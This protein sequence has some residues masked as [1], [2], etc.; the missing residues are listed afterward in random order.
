MARGDRYHVYQIF[1][2]D[3][4]TGLGPAI[5]EDLFLTALP[6]RLDAEVAERLYGPRGP[7]R[8]RELAQGPY[9]INEE[10]AGSFR[11]HSLFREFLTQRWIEE[12]GAASLLEQRSQLA[13]WYRETGDI[14]SAYQ[15]AC[16]AQDW[17]TAVAAIDAAIRPLANQADS[18]FVLEVL[19]RLPED[20]IRQ[21]R[22]LWESWVR[23]LSH[24]GDPRALSEATAL[25]EAPGSISEQGLADLLLAELRHDHGELSDEELAVAC[26]AIALRL[27][28][29]DPRLAVQARFMALSARAVRSGSPEQWPRLLEVAREVATEAKAAAMP[30]VAAIALAQA[31]DLAG[32]IFQNA[33]MQD[34]ATLR[35]AA[36]FGAAPPLEQRL[37]RARQL[38]AVHDAALQLYKEAFSLAEETNDPLTLAHVQLSYSRSTTAKV[39]DSVLRTGKI[40]E[41]ERGAGEAAIQ[42]ALTAA[43][44]Y[45][46]R[47]VLRSVAVCFN[48]AAEAASV[49]NDH[50]RRDGFCDQSASLVHRSRNKLLVVAA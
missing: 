38:L 39:M 40:A 30:S 50:Q 22:P 11:V 3:Y 15:I 45:A 28:P 41:A 49:L 35:F 42:Y 10:A 21:S 34:L 26:D 13:R 47:G 27:T 2:T 18:Y 25:A 19:Q 31:G 12:R 37:K 33:F 9:F 17:E 24:L 20:R 1:A 23:A 36:S 8:I 4:F 46:E 5:R 6:L 14:A 48:A 29:E 16:E 44:A 43:A 32:R 7:L